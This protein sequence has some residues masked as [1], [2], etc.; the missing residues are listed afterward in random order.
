M[1]VNSTILYS[2]ADSLD[3][4]TY[5][6]RRVNRSEHIQAVRIP[7]SCSTVCTYQA[8]PNIYWILISQSWHPVFTAGA[9]PNSVL[10]WIRALSL[11][12]FS[13]L[14]LSYSLA[15]KCAKLCGLFGRFLSS[16]RSTAA[17]AKWENLYPSLLNPG[18]SRT[19]SNPFFHS[20][21]LK[22]FPN[23]IRALQ[24]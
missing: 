2:T 10:V 16:I 8:H 13:L 6:G 17:T 15:T 11:G 1:L 12:S 4:S 23:L 24:K 20:S 18:I 9:V 19:L 3:G 7:S 5:T 22:V 14:L 21:H